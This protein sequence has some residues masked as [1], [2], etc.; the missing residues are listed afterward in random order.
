MRQG[1]PRSVLSGLRGCAE[2]TL[3][4]Y[5]SVP[6]PTRTCLSRRDAG[7]TCPVI[8]AYTKDRSMALG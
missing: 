3:V 6:L 4:R 8:L 1:P 2:M 5:G 7:H